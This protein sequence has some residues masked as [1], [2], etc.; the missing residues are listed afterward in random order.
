VRVRK[1]NF[2][3]IKKRVGEHLKNVFGV[4]EFKITFAKQEEEVWRV[5]VEFKERDGAIEMP[6]TAQLSVDI[7]TGE[8]KELRK[9]YSWGF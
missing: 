5:N 3:E 4:E 8:I 9:G 7:R 2:E 1:L 6:S